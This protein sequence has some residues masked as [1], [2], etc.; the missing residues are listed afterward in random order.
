MAVAATLGV[1]TTTAATID[2]QLTGITR[3]FPPSGAPPTA[4]LSSSTATWQFDDT[5]DVLTQ[6]DGILDAQ[7]MGFTPPATFFRHS[8]TGLVIGGG[9]AATASMFI[10]TEGNFAPSYLAASMCGSYN[11]GANFIDE[12]L[13]SYGPG[14][15][16][17][18]TIGGDD[19]VIDG[20]GATGQQN[21][22]DYNGFTMVSWNGVV[23]TLSNA[24]CNTQLSGSASGC[25]AFPGNANSGYTWTL[26]PVPVPTAAWFIAPVFGLLAPWVK[27]RQATA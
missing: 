27:R 5:T 1:S 24:S 7:F 16:Y 18:R 15:A 25:S 17:G 19:V 2:L 10:C 3:Y 23:L 8:I 4:T 9:A 22:A 21:I 12:S 11:F 6:T 20:T 13:I 14:V 26:T